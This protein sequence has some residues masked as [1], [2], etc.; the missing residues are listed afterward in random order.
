MTGDSGDVDPADGAGI[1]E[2]VERVLAAA[3]MLGGFPAGDLELPDPD[4]WAWPNLDGD[5]ANCGGLRV[6]DLRRAGLAAADLDDPEV[7]E[8]AWR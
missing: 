4:P 3:R 5:A 6:G 8:R 1:A 2:S 7:M